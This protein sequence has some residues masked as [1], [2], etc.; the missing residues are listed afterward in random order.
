[1]ESTEGWYKQIIY[2]LMEFCLKKS[3]TF[4]TL[5]FYVIYYVTYC[6]PEI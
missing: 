1:M 5:L 4:W 6:V 2:E 3:S